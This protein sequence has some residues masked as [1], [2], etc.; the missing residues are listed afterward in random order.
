MCMVHWIYHLQISSLLSV[1]LFNCA[2]SSYECRNTAA[3]SEHDILPSVAQRR[4]RHGLV[5]VNKESSSINQSKRDEKG[6]ECQSLSKYIK[7]H[8]GTHWPVR[9]KTWRRRSCNVK[10]GIVCQCVLFQ[11]IRLYLQSHD[12]LIKSSEWCLRY[13]SGKAE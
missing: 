3:L 12:L 8:C 6:E 7:D 9:R 13:W 1:I 10:L 5:Q 4:V 11:Q 2:V